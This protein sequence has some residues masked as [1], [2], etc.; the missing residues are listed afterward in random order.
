MFVYNFHYHFNY[1]DKIRYDQFNN[2]FKGISNLN[3]LYKMKFNIFV[4][5]LNILVFTSAWFYTLYF[6]I[7]PFPELLSIQLYLLYVPYLHLVPIVKII[8]III[9]NLDLDMFKYLFGYFKKKIL[10]L[11]KR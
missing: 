9:F 1:F 8:P 6:I 10:K 4:F 11:M 7:F 2:K 5:I 3:V